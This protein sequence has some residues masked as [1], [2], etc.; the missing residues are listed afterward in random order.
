MIE[1]LGQP[2]QLAQLL[3]AAAERA[4]RSL[5]EL[6]D[7]YR[8]PD[9]VAIRPWLRANMVAS[10]DGA[11]TVAGRASGLGNRTD[12]QLLRVLRGL[13]DVVIAGAS[14]VAAEGYGPIKARP[15]FAARR[16]AAGQPAA[17]TVVV[18]SRQL[19]LDVSSKLFTTGSRRPIV[20]TCTDA[21]AARRSR[22]AAVADLID[23]GDDTVEPAV[24]LKELAARGHRRLLCEGGPTLLGQL[25]DVLDEVCV[26]ISPLLV[27][28]SSPRIA[29]GPDGGAPRP[30]KLT[31]LLRDDDDMLFATYEVLR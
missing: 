19:D 25:V 30:M 9:S 27:G 13:A 6:A 22:V 31:Q 1:I 18:V 5:D 15:E 29:H 23:A 20:V 7:A 4:V 21:P 11:A 28:G 26:T 8:Y 3:P 17:A 12:Q 16:A 24:M 2:I 14:T 10:V